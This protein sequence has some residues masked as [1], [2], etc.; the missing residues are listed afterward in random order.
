[1]LKDAMFVHGLILN[2]Y[3]LDNQAI[4]TE[5]PPPYDQIYDELQSLAFL[6]DELV[7]D[8]SQEQSETQSLR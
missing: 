4:A 6:V 2:F 7:S 1:M 5:Q 8:F 3:I